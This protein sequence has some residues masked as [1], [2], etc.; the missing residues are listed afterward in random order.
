ME[1]I[2]MRLKNKILKKG[3]KKDNYSL[4]GVYLSLK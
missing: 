3:N 2:I 1:K 4:F